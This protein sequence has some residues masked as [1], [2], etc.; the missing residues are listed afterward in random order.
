[1]FLNHQT[2]NFEKP[3]LTPPLGLHVLLLFEDSKIDSDVVDDVTVSNTPPWGQHELHICL[4]LTKSKKDCT[5][6]EVYK[7]FG[8]YFTTPKLC[9]DFYR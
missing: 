1:M 8:N 3:K 9:S 7:L 4:A 6:P 2:Q 5:S